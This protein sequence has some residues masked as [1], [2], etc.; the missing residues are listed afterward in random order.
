MDSV[1]Y[2]VYNM[3]SKPLKYPQQTIDRLKLENYSGGL[4]FIK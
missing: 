2:L 1:W 4:T 3:Q